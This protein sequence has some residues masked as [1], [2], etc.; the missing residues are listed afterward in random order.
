MLHNKNQIKETISS[1]KQQRDQL[2]LQIHLGAMEAKEE[3]E[4]AK[5]KLDQMT[6]QFDPVK[7]AIDESATNVLASLKLVGEEVLASFNRI[8]ES[9]K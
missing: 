4:A 7:D 2:A 6:A 9:L 3:F 8:R 5:V 1:L